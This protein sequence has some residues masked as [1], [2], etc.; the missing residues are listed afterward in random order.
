MR[1]AYL[2][3]ASGISGDM[4]LGAIIDAGVELERIQASIDS[5]GLPSCRLAVQEA[6]RAGFRASDLTVEHQPEHAHRHLHHITAMIDR[7]TLTPRQREMAT[8][9]FQRLG[10][11]E[12]KVHGTTIQKV[13]FHEVGAV[14]SIADIVGC[15]VGIDLL[16]VDRIVCSPL[17]TGSGFVQIAHGRCSIPAPATAELLQGIPLSESRIE[18]EL[19]TPTGAAIVASLV[20]QFGPLPPLRIEQI[21]YGAGDR[22]FPEQPN[23]LRLLVGKSGP[24]RLTDQVVVMETNLDDVSPEII[25]YCFDR[26]LSAGALDVFMAAIQ[27]KKS[28]PGIKITVLCRPNDASVMEEILFQETSTLGIRQWLADRRVVARETKTVSTPWG[29]I[30]GKL[31]RMPSGD[32]RFSPEFEE[33]R[34]VAVE[35]GVPL[36][37]V[38]EAAIRAFESTK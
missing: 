31:A 5:L 7:S 26:L 21:G 13:H 8:C 9:V 2:D 17:P 1:I 11:A 14:D 37:T 15:C 38:M 27:M 19:T 25:G 12:A 16:N 34:A 3:C 18:A 35:R 4:L 10:E 28:R 6:K 29:P 33:C 36:H 32:E 20:D 22:D 23:I 30:E 24:E